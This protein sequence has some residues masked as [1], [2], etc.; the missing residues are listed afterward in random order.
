[1]SR[2]RILFCLTTSLTSIYLAL[3][4]SSSSLSKL[5]D[6]PFWKY[7]WSQ[8]QKNKLLKLTPNF[9][10]FIKARWVERFCQQQLFFTLLFTVFRRGISKPASSSSHWI[11]TC[12]LAEGAVLR[13]VLMNLRHETWK[14]EPFQL[15]NMPRHKHDEDVN[16]NEWAKLIQ[17]LKFNFIDNFYRRLPVTSIVHETVKFVVGR[18]VAMQNFIL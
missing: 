3:Q 14:E 4:I 8:Q 16:V 9:N 18:D 11:W 1:M 2:W 12:F 17:C 6:A 7:E 15:F 10:Y 5:L 13:K